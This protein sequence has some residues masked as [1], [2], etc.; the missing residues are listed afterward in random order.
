MRL[1][2]LRPPAAEWY[3]VNIRVS[4]TPVPGKSEAI[5]VNDE[6]Q[7]ENAALAPGARLRMP[8]VEAV[9]QLIVVARYGFPE[10]ID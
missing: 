4:R 6:L 9:R 7:A 1:Q 8:I 3:H 2:S 10:V 5:T